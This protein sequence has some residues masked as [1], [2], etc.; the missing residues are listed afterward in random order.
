M[1]KGLDMQYQR[2]LIS[3]FEREPEKWR[4][5]VRRA[6]GMPVII[7]GLKKLDEFVTGIDSNTAQAAL[8]AAMAA[9]DAGTF[10]Q[11][12]GRATESEA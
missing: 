1:P 10:S 12:R 5:K 8:L 7:R 4:A 2:F 3:A 11:N 6:D 9:I